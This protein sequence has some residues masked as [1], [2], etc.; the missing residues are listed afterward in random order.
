MS[1]WTGLDETPPAEGAN[2]PLAPMGTGDS[3]VLLAQLEVDPANGWTSSRPLA[4]VQL[5]YF[6][7]FAQRPMVVEQTINAEMVGNLNGYDPI[8]DLEV[9]RNVTIQQAAEGMRRIDRLAQAGQY[10]E[11]WRLA[12]EFEDRLNEVAHLTNDNQL[13][14]DANLMQRYQQTLADALWQSEGRQPRLADVVRPMPSQQY[15]AAS[16]SGQTP[17]PTPSVPV[18]EIQ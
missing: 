2:V 8:W 12:V 6:D 16:N 15:P 3:A 11:G 9:L 18:V 14:E 5:H 4:Q 13:L 7:E 1:A 17:I 10:E